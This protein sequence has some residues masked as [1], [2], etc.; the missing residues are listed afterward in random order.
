VN[1][2]PAQ[3]RIIAARGLHRRVVTGM[4]A[5]PSA[6]LSVLA[7]A[8]IIATLLADW[9]WD[10]VVVQAKPV[11]RPKQSKP[12]SVAEAYT[13]I[14]TAEAF[15]SMRQFQQWAHASAANASS[16]HAASVP[17]VQFVFYT[18]SQGAGEDSLVRG[19]FAQLN[20]NLG[21]AFH[22]PV[23]PVGDVVHRLVTAHSDLISSL[24]ARDG[25]HPGA[26]GA[27]LAALVLYQTIT[28]QSPVGLPFAQVSGLDTTTAAILQQAV[29]DSHG[30]ASPSP[31][32]ML[33]S[34]HESG[35]SDVSSINLPADPESTDSTNTMPVVRARF[36]TTVSP[37][38]DFNQ[39]VNGGWIRSPIASDTAHSA[40]RRRSQG[41]LAEVSA[42]AQSTLRTVLEAARKSAV[43][44]HDTMADIMTRQAGMFYGSCVLH[45]RQDSLNVLLGLGD[46]PESHCVT[47]TQRQFGEAASHAYAQA[48]LG[49]AT[50]AELGA[51]AASLRTAMAERLKHLPWMQDTTRRYA[52]AKLVAMQFQFGEAS[53]ALK[54]NTLKLSPTD[55][56]QNLRAIQ[57]W[58]WR[59]KLAGIGEAPDTNGWMLG[60]Y[61]A[62][63]VNRREMNRV[64]IPAALLQPPLFVLDTPGRHVDLATN[65]GGLGVIVGHEISHGFDQKGQLYGINGTRGEWWTPQDTLTF[66]QYLEP[67]LAS[68]HAMSGRL[69]TPDSGPR[70]EYIMSELIADLGGVNI[71]YDAFE[72][73]LHMLPSAQQH[74][75][76]HGFTPEQRFFL[77]YANIWRSRDDPSRAESGPNPHP[78]YP[79]RVNGILANIPAFAHAFGCKAGDPMV[80]SS[81]D[82]VKLW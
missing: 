63:A 68:Y 76:R 43:N 12:Q 66:R 34:T 71:A 61:V 69:V 7:Q 46:T 37:C 26:A 22:A 47:E 15:R 65:Y 14:D 50:Y 23:A 25:V 58:H 73:R 44:P 77:A 18:A 33:V 49:S 48:M 20:E 24:F 5:M 56:L 8:K 4:V 80:R 79:F 59:Q 82:R 81:T 10:Y 21:R 55:Y 11:L 27:Y 57:A 40:R 17:A 13:W 36:D 35:S 64:E 70:M 75:R 19:V 38:V 72:T 29:A 74:I 45:A 32:A 41:T 51:I 53:T 2:V 30:T 39:Y 78:R 67:L 54:T 9:S 16:T 52:L 60:V 42:R 1:N 28:H 31:R 3:F 6:E 62:N